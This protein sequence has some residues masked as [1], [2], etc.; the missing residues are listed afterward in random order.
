MSEI[1]KIEY[2]N[3]NHPSEKFF[4]EKFRSI[5]ELAL[6]FQADLVKGLK[7]SDKKDLEEREKR[8]GN[9]HLPPEKENSILEHIKECL[10][11]PMLQILL[12]ASIVS[13]VIGVAK[14]G[15]GTGWI[16]GSAIFLAVFL[17][18]SISSYLNYN[19]TE[20]F[21]QLS[22]ENKF[23]KVILLRDGKEEEMSIEA[24]LA[25]DILKLRIGDIVGV[26]G[27]ILDGYRVG[28]DESPVS[29]ESNIMWKENKFEQ[30]G[31]EE[32]K[33]IT[34]FI[35]SGSQVQEG[36]GYMLVTA[37][38]SNTF[39]SRSNRQ[40]ADAKIGGGDDEDGNED[41]DLTPLQAQLN[42]LANL[43]GDLGYMMAIAIGVALIIKETLVKYYKGL[44]IFD[45]TEL[46]IVVNAFIIA[47]TVIVVAIPEGLPMAVAISFAYSVQK[48]KHEH[49]LVKRMDKSEAMGNVNNVCTDKTG[50]L[51]IGSMNVVTIF[52][53]E[54]DIKPINF[55]EYSSEDKDIIYEG[56]QK[57]IAVVETVGSN[58]EITLSGDMTEKALYNFMKKIMQN[59]QENSEKKPLLL[60]PFKSDY[61]YMISIH[62][63]KD[64]ET[65]YILYAKGALE[66]LMPFMAKYLNSE[67][68]E[69][70]FDDFKNT[71]IEKQTDYSDHSMRTLVFGTKILSKDEIDNAKSQIE[72]DPDK[73]LDIFKELAEG[74][75][76]TFMVGI[77]DDI[78]PEVPDSIIRCH[79]AGITVRMVTGDNFNT[80]LAIAKDCHIIKD[81]EEL[82]KAKQIAEKYKNFVNNKDDN[83]LKK[84]K[85]L[86]QE[87]PIAL[88][89][90]TFRYLTGNLSKTQ[91]KKKGETDVFLNDKERFK[92]V[93][94][95]LKV[96]ARASP[97]DKFL[98]VM[99]L[100]ELGN[101]VAVTGDGT[102]DAPAL[103]QSHVG[104][105]MGIRGT[106][107]AKDAADVVLLDD[108]FSSII[109][110]CKYGRNVYDCIRKF[111]Q[112]QLTVN[113]VAV[114]MTFLG[115]IIL[116]DSP[117][118][119]IQM[120]WVNLIM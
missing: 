64:N 55:S 66:T 31:E 50:T 29:G 92:F 98:L 105:A 86:M 49:N 74:L 44:P 8:W 33:Y 87:S 59:P 4:K 104:F 96:I 73:T 15:W 5:E 78:R 46:D 97:E 47:V 38:G 57:N 27:Y 7:N 106:D 2:I 11:D 67:L 19:K 18:T 119:A 91:G 45:S 70:N 79:D 60:L 13:L 9:N 65:E 61:K 52:Y 84:N 1:Y 34:P 95:D 22:R 36:F 99:G 100:K 6:Y 111:I 93:I 62:P 82:Q 115:G 71:L 69:Q 68:K 112:F 26:D 51:T 56:I 83:K 30:A 53:K 75:T 37:V 102:N 42:D 88:E 103:R 120:L 72:I 12:A 32:Y 39:E 3:Q 21:L 76:F 110:A 94:K 118:N 116:N 58:G 113:I 41:A 24:I 14:D 25:G 81:E 114:F 54:I 63:S 17:V 77:R 40:L 48:M 35:L 90:E 10:E 89:G 80:A 108:S 43:I 117:L 20:Q 109:T 107:I 23:K 28:M 16:E 85:E 101:I